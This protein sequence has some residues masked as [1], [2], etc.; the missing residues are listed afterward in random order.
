[1]ASLLISRR[2]HTRSYYRIFV[3][4]KQGLNIQ[5][6]YITVWR[7]ELGFPQRQIMK[8]HNFRN[9]QSYFT[10]ILFK[11]NQSE[12]K[13]DE[14]SKHAW[15]QGRKYTGFKSKI[16]IYK[17]RSITTLTG[18]VIAIFEPV[19][20]FSRIHHCNIIMPII[21]AA[22]VRWYFL[23]FNGNNSKVYV[24]HFFIMF[25]INIKITIC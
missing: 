22:V 7:L 1:M 8:I 12:I 14:N 11:I 15:G 4:G 13:K 18:S 21:F 3:L 19:R 2:S 10:S 16:K 23:L 24:N 25:R 20:S 5:L 17:I 9:K 6:I